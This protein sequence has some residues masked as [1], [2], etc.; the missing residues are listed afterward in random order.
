MRC[1]QTSWQTLGVL[2]VPSDGLFS[3]KA[4]RRNT[5]YKLKI[6]TEPPL[7]G[8]TS[9]TYKEKGGTMADIHNFCMMADTSTYGTKAY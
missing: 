3:A 5:I 7:Y 4:K 2:Q 9:K 8:E 1:M 6:M